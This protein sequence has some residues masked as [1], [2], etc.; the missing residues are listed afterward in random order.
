[1]R[2]TIETSIDDD[3][4]I[5]VGGSGP[6]DNVVKHLI[7][8]YGGIAAVVSMVSGGL[9][10]IPALKNNKYL[11]GATKAF[12]AGMVAYDF[13][14]KVRA[15]Y[16]TED[17]SVEDKK[18]EYI[19]S[20]LGIDE[21]EY[22]YRYNKREIHMT[23]EQIQWVLF[24]AHST[25]LDGVT[26][27]GYYDIENGKKLA[28]VP[29]NGNFCVM[30]VY[31]N[32]NFLLEFN[33]VGNDSLMGAMFTFRKGYVEESGKMYPFIDTLNARYM[34][35]MGFDKNVILYDGYTL[36][37]RPRSELI[38]FEV[39]TVDF[40]HLKNNIVRVL[41]EGRRR[42]LLFVGNP[43][44]GKTTILLK[45][46][47]ELKDYPIMYA[48]AT[49]INDENSINRLTSFIKKLGKCVVFIEDMDALEL[50][51]KTAKIAPLLSLLDNSRTGASVV[52]ISTINDASL[53][54]ES[55]V[56][57]GRFDEVIEIHEP[58][59]NQSIHNILMTQWKKLRPESDWGEG[60]PVDYK[61]LSWRTYARLKYHK[62]TQ[63]DYCELAQKI[64]MNDEELND[65]NLIKAM[66]EL[67]VSKQAFKKY[68]K[69][70]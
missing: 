67:V 47:N 10:A 40:P 65:K 31:D 60:Y 51:K 44:T 6:N 68:M 23:H 45:L 41:N 28:C 12:S 39:D 27:E 43:G 52:F 26:I 15:Y 30:F 58:K 50:G 8:S 48:T 32:T 46:E 3:E 57:T 17:V 24:D 61:C 63:S 1:M 69:D 7:Y 42:G 62:L 70:D 35:S 33:T 53:I 20:I 66:K 37:T 64:H 56:R 38:D 29:N 13:Y 5:E 55:I 36:S 49:N 14:N 21:D 19:D 16:T 9:N 18:E 4:D 2:D 25:D 22:V 59:Y 54:T 34:D 11:S